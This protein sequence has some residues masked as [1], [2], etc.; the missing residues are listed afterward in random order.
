MSREGWYENVPHCITNHDH[1]LVCI[2]DCNIHRH[3]HAHA[4]IRV[5]V[6]VFVYCILLLQSNDTGLYAT[7]M[8][9]GDYIHISEWLTPYTELCQYD[10]LSWQLCTAAEVGSTSYVCT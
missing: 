2:V 10:A 1:G 6:H 8:C 5:H 3:T 4:C 9:Y 7:R